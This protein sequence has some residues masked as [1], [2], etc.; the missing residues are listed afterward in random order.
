MS[1]IKRRV[2]PFSLMSRIRGLLLAVL[3]VLVV[4]WVAVSAGMPRPAATP[5]PQPA[6]TPSPPERLVDELER[7]AERLRADL[8]A[9]A[10]RPDVPT[11]NPFRFADERAPR[12]P[13]PAVPAVGIPREPAAP[14]PVTALHPRLVGL[15]EHAEEGSVRRTAII[16]VEGALEFVGVGD[17]VAGTFEVVSIDAD[18]VE[19]R[20]LADGTTTRLTH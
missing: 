5:P 16:S 4:V 2:V 9:A 15:A 12:T 10:A 7:T 3:A 13:A 8:D 19:L 18:G 17:Q 6:R 1:R 14:A 20:R 11:R